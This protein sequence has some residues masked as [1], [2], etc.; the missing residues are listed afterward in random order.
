ME[1][2]LLFP[3]C[4]AELVTAHM[5]WFLIKREC[6]CTDVTLKQVIQPVSVLTQ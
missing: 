2:N 5:D 4:T 6:L 3:A 1:T